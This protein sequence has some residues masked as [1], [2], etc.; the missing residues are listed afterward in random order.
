MA[1]KLSLNL[2]P[3]KLTQ[4]NVFFLAERLLVFI[5]SSTNNKCSLYFV[6]AKYNSSAAST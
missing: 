2:E 3:G 5:F 6:A 4:R 1:T